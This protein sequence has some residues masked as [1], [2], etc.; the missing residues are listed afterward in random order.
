M[1]NYINHEYFLPRLK[2]FTAKTLDSYECGYPY[3]PF[4][5]YTF[6]L[7]QSSP[8]KIFYVGKD[9]YYWEEYQSLVSQDKA[10]LLDNY[11]FQNSQ[12]VDVNSSLNWKNNSGSF[13]NMVDKLHL[14]IRTGEYYPDILKIGEKEKQILEEIGYGNLYSI[15]LPETLKK[16]ECWTE[17]KSLH[18][19]A[20]IR[21]EAHVF[22]NLKT[23]IDAYNPDMVFVFGWVEKDDF[24]DG[25]EFTWIEPLYEEGFRSV[26]LS[27]NC[28]TKVIWTSHPRR[29]SFLGTNT[30]E[31]VK[32]LADSYQL[33]CK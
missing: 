18:Q 3:G 8:L 15:E 20:E 25:T 21:K 6:G 16:E 12:C 10:P 14:M 22:E 31:M 11:L 29:F 17:L 24:F 9:T 30:E 26:F 13:W 4:I 2:E 23:L 27:E 1:D 33:I 28:K 5:P 19:Y 32:Y 7:Y